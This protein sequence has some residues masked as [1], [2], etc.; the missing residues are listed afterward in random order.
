MNNGMK[1][2]TGTELKPKEMENACGGG[3][4]TGFYRPDPAMR[5]KPLTGQP[6]NERKDS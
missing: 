1:E 4:I 2:N 6:E 5:R 3:V